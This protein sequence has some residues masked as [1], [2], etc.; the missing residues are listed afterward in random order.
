M[1]FRTDSQAQ[2]SQGIQ[3]TGRLTA[4]PCACTTEALSSAIVASACSAT[5]MRNAS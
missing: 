1:T 2:A 3:I 5:R 4:T